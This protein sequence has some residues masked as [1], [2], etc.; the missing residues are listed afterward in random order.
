MNNELCDGCHHRFTRWGKDE[1]VHGTPDKF[2]CFKCKYFKSFSIDDVC[3]IRIAQERIK[4]LWD[5]YDSENP[6]FDSEQWNEDFEIE[7]N[8]I[9]NIHEGK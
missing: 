4:K 3:K 7:Q 9:R 5:I 1:I 8:N 2:P 6:N